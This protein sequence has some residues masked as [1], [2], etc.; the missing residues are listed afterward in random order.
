MKLETLKGTKDF[1]PELQKQL[2]NITQIISKQFE[3]YGFQPFDT[4]QV[5]YYD[6]LTYK[7][8]EDAE[9]VQEIFKLKD[10]GERDLGLRYDLTTPLMRYVAANPHLKKPFKRYQIGKVFRDGPLKKGRM[11]EF[12]QCDADTVGIEGQEIEVDMLTLFYEVYKKLG[13]D[14]IIEINN[15]KIL[16]GA[17]LQSGGNQEN[18]SQYILSID[19]LKK[20][21]KDKVLEEISEKGLDKN[22]ASNALEILSSKS[23][24]ELKNKATSQVLNEGIDELEELVKYI[25]DIPIILNFTLARGLDIYTGNIWEAYDKSRKVTS[26]IGAGGRYDSVIGEFAQDGNNYPA[27][28]ISFGITP[29]LSCLE[30][31]KEE[32]TTQ[33]L[34]A[35][36]S[37]EVL[38]ESFKLAK[39]YRE[40]NYTTQIAF[41]YSLKKIFKYSDSINAKYL[42]LLGEEDIKNQEYTIKNLKTK[43]EVKKPLKFN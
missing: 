33:I 22:I 15:N 26:S 5:E 25:G 42:I 24:E 10:R 18:L 14:T 2:Q 27:V 17:I 9:I 30:K 8:D 3:L 13:I 12:Y 29:I 38:E 40:K 6:I 28:G 41:Q 34:I 36:L 19:K 21:G 16:Q 39:V 7:Y 35:P 23:I 4:P 20:I 31:E 1:E 11:R 37:R 43:E 32:I